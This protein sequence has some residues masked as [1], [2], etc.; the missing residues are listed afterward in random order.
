MG[1]NVAVE[2]GRK[3]DIEIT[4]LAGVNVLTVATTRER[5]AKENRRADAAKRGRPKKLDGKQESFVVVL[6]CSNAP[7]G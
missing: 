2:R 5:W 4:E 1:A 6:A 3:M 7:E